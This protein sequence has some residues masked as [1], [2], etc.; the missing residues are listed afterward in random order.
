MSTH[1][2][3][4]YDG[5]CQSL[6]CSALCKHEAGF[7]Y[8]NTG[9]DGERMEC[10]ACGYECEHEDTEVEGGRVFCLLCSEHVRNLDRYDDPNIP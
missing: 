6:D 8:K 1:V 9:F 2:H 4:F 3:E 5:Q 10:K 7:T